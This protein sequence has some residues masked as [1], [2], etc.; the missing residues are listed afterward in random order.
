MR[1]APTATG[2]SHRRAGVSEHRDHRRRAEPT[3]TDR[4]RVNTSEAAQSTAVTPATLRCQRAMPGSCGHDS[5]DEAD[6]DRHAVADRLEEWPARASLVDADGRVRY[7]ARK[8]ERGEPQGLEERCDGQIQPDRHEAAEKHD[9]CC[10][11][12]KIAGAS[13]K[14]RNPTIPT[15]SARRSS[16]PCRRTSLLPGPTPR[17]RPS[18]RRAASGSARARWARRLAPA[19]P[20]R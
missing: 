17:C 16:A 12:A 2:S 5:G 11:L 14:S 4:V 13:A 15:R 19:G 10:A 7:V 8:H 3:Q 6:V 1:A 20:A 18:W 9:R